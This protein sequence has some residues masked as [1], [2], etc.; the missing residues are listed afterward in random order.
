MAGVSAAVLMEWAKPSF[1]EGAARPLGAGSRVPAGHI[2]RLLARALDHDVRPSAVPVKYEIAGIDPFD[3]CD[4][5]RGIVD[6]D[7][8]S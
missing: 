7:K 4:F 1:A 8:M 6:F 2:Q 3:D 5:C